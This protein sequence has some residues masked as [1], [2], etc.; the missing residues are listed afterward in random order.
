MFSSQGTY[1]ACGIFS[2]G[3]FTLLIITIIGIWLALKYT[4]NKSREDIRKI[5]RNVTIVAWIL[6]IVKIIFNVRQNSFKAI[7]T[8]IPLYYCSILLYAGLLS[9]FAKGVFKRAG[10]VFIATGAIIGGIVFM[11][12]PSTSLPIYPM[13]HFL[14]IHSFLYHG[15]MVY[16]GI[17]VN[18]TNYVKIE[19]SDIKY[20]A[21]IMGMICFIALIINKAFDGNLMFISN[22]FPGTPLEIIYEFTGGGLLYTIIM[23]IAQLVLPFYCSYYILNDRINIEKQSNCKYIK[24]Q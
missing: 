9:S 24:L 3:H 20:F 19:K 1:K 21:S 23:V 22:N 11:I 8:Y 16:L 2:I 7:N 6:E 15:A 5:I 4:K 18:I 14:S 13:F 12:Y 10:D 17:L